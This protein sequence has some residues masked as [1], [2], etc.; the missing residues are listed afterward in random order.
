MHRHTYTQVYVCV[1]IYTHAV[2]I[3]GYVFIY[4]YTYIY[5][6]LY[7]QEEI[8]WYLLAYEYIIQAYVVTTLGTP[9]TWT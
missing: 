9:V 1:Y 7:T 2:C 3:Y 6:R 5:V 8:Q 4:A